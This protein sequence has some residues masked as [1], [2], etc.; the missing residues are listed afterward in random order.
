MQIVVRWLIN[1]FLLINLMMTSSSFAQK[2]DLTGRELS[3][4]AY[5]SYI[6][7]FPL[8]I[9]DV[10][11]TVMTNVPSPS[12]NRRAPINQFGHGDKFPTPDYND[13]VRPNA[14]TLYSFAW[15][16]LSKEPFVLSIPDTK[17]R[18][19]LLPMLDAWTE[20]FASPGK[21]TTGTGKRDFV[22]LGPDWVGELPSNLEV[23]KA[24]TNIVWIM[25]RTLTLGE[26]D[27]DTV[28]Q[29]QKGY[30][31]TPLS[32]WGKDYIPPANVPTDPSIDMSSPAAQVENMDAILFFTRVA[33]VLKY[34]APHSE[35]AEMLKQL[36]RIGIFPGKDFDASS[37]TSSEIKVLNQAISAALRDIKRFVPKNSDD[38]NGWIITKI[39]GHYGTAYMER[40]AIAYGG[41]GANLP[42]DAIYPAAFKDIENNIL[43]GKN[44]YI[45]HFNADQLPPV[46]GFWSV[47]MYG[48]G[49]YFIS[50]AIDRYA[51]GD[52]SVLE[53][54]DDGSLDIYVQHDSP[55]FNKE[56][57]WLPAPEGNFN[58]TMRLYWPKQDVYNGYWNP[59]TVRKN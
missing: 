24:P 42:E 21:R 51:I 23:I 38:K 8:V 10:S 27:Y 45:I 6:Y 20:I 47:T 48:F 1:I 12:T 30:R 36:E 49:G 13:F 3:I 37:Y 52:R 43:S 50:N 32:Q 7:T 33:K 5:N 58:L 53:F 22:V 18:Y 14:D 17:D 41:L 28:H 40:A 15:L 55:G 44:K 26:D 46:N 57:N 2:S 11:K 31:L 4:A 25:G 16:D 9:M 39:T 59:P 56:S 34:N 35:D 54:N 29:I 19:F